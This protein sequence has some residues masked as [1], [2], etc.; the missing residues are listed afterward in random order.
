[1]SRVPSLIALRCLEAAARLGSFTRAARELNLTQ[2]AV[3]RQVIGLEAR[4]ATPM[5]ARRRESLVPTEACRR[6]LD[7]IAPALAALERATANVLAAGARGGILNLS[8]ASSFC[9]YWLIPR[10]PRFTHAH[11]EITVNLSTQVGRADF[12]RQR[13]DAAIEFGRGARDGLSAVPLMPLTLAPVAAPAWAR[14][15]RQRWGEGLRPDRVAP[16]LIHHVTVPNAWARWS[17][18]AGVTAPRLD[19]GPRYE[20]MSMAL[21][22]ATSGLGAVLL[23]DFMTAEALHRRALTRLGRVTWTAD[24]AYYVVFSPASADSAPLRALLAWLG[25]EAGAH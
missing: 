9:N 25:A 7:D 2:G 1:M 3:S 12:V 17:E 8:V 24:A 20:L 15:Y 21:T 23:P 22:A 14:A 11:P 5:F 6:Y 10:L 16:Q 4:L 13:I 18:R 19:L